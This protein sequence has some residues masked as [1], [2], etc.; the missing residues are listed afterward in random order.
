[1]SSWLFIKS[2]AAAMGA[3]T[4]RRFSAAVR[5]A[6]ATAPGVPAMAPIR[7]PRSSS[8]DSGTGPPARINAIWRAL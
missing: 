4:N 7:P 6:A 1:M 8:C 3:A 5:S 2:R